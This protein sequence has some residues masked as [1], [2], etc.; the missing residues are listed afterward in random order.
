MLNHKTGRSW[1]GVGAHCSGS[2][3]TSVNGRWEVA[4]CNT[5]FVSSFIIIIIFPS[6]LVLLSCLYFKQVLPFFWFSLHPTVGGASEWLCGVQLPARINHRTWAIPS[7]PGTI[8]CHS[9][10][11]TALLE[12]GCS[13]LGHLPFST[14]QGPGL[15]HD[16]QWQ[17]KDIM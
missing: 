2:G 6:F 9:P 14:F 16:Q 3:W 4:L 1:L 11:S 12:D 15:A 7:A 13:H 5:G 8:Q 17:K 10:A